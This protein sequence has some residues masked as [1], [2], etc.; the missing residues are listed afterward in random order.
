M[1]A[2]GSVG[3][4]RAA[5][6]TPV[7]REHPEVPSEVRDLRL[8]E[9][10]VE[11]RPGRRQEDRSLAREWRCRAVPVPRDPDAVA[12]ELTGRVREPGP[13]GIE[14]RSRSGRD[15]LAYRASASRMRAP[16]L[17]SADTGGELALVE[18]QQDRRLRAQ[19]RQAHE[20]RHLL[21]GERPEPTHPVRLAPRDVAQQPVPAAEQLTD[22]GGHGVVR[23]ARRDHLLEHAD[24]PRL[25]VLVQEVAGHLPVA[26]QRLGAGVHPPLPFEQAGVLRLEHREDQQLLAPEVVVDL[27]QRHARF[28]G[29]R[30]RREV[31]VPLLEQP[32][33]SGGE[34]GRARLGGRLAATLGA[35]DGS[36]GLGF[37][38]P[39]RIRR[40][41]HALTA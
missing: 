10:A 24:V 38:G 21:G 40:A 5:V 17:R 37:H 25:E 32:R 36:G 4:V 1:Y 29:D 3:P 9:P 28:L 35:R 8:P 33:S 12:H 20:H 23:P 11:D 19:E 6:A 22:R 18:A 13:G 7:P 39:P 26:P 41:G 34:D 27:A 31:G 14:R 2:A 30:P 15:H 16:I